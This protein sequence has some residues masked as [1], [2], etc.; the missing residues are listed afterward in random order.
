MPSN[1]RKARII[2]IKRNLQMYKHL[3]NDRNYAGYNGNFI[4][5]QRRG[6]RWARRSVYHLLNKHYAKQVITFMAR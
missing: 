1:Q 2:L 5:K 6:S 3:K 4:L